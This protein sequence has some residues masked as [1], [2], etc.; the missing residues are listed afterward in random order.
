MRPSD[1]S[2]DE[3]QDVFEERAIHVGAGFTAQERP[4]VVETLATLGAHLRR[5]NP[6]A[7]G[8][9]VSVQDR[10]GKEQRITLRRT[11]PGLPQLVAV[12]ADRDMTRA[13]CEAKRELIA[14]IDHHEVRARTEEQPSAPERDDPASRT[15]NVH[16]QCG[17]HAQLM[18]A[19]HRRRAPIGPCRG[20]GRRCS[21]E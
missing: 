3:R 15:G 12:A 4:H 18:G 5:S 10:G 8:V 11:L 21:P 1:I 17:P 6:D 9:E 20:L 7:V 16:L 13:L 19:A 2:D 14:Q